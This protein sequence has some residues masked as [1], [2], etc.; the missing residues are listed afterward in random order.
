MPAKTGE[1]QVLDGWQWI[2]DHQSEFIELQRVCL[3]IEASVKPDGR[4][5]FSSITCQSIYMLAE[6]MRIEISNDAVFRRNKS[7]WSTISRYLTAMYP[8]LERV[9]EHRACDVARYV[10]MRGLPKIGP[11]YYYINRAA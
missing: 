1:Q 2:V 9:I 11:E 10:L 5:R 8:Q 7:H 6:I 3:K 4:K